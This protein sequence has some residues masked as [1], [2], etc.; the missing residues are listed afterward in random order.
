[1]GDDV[2]KVVD[3]IKDAGRE[4]KHRTE[5]GLEH[6]KRDIAGDEMTA[7]EK[8]KSVVHEDVEN[9]KADVDH[10]KRAVRDKT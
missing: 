6:A 9:T 2:K 3:D 10:A 1:M 5:A 7:G 4:A 8:I